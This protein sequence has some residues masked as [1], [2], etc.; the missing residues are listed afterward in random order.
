MLQVYKLLVLQEHFHL[1]FLRIHYLRVLHV[2]LVFIVKKIQLIT[3]EIFV[4]LGITAQKVVKQRNLMPVLQALF[5]L[6]QD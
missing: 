4:L 3:Q 1:E 2:L 5:R 6:Q